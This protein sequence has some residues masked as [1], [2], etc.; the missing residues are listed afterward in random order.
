[1]NPRRADPPLPPVDPGPM[2]LGNNDANTYPMPFINLLM[3]CMAVILYDLGPVIT[4]DGMG[5]I[6]VVYRKDEG[7]YMH[8]MI[9]FSMYPD[10]GTVAVHAGPE[11]VFAA[12]IQADRFGFFEGWALDVHELDNTFVWYF[13]YPDE[14]NRIRLLSEEL[15]NV[16]NDFPW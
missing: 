3:A 16:A 4:W 5:F 9:D 8:I 12:A 7:V 15:A 14:E 11:R 6:D 1:M 2:D 10:D 13:T